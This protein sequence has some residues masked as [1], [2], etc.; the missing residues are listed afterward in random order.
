VDPRVQLAAP[1]QVGEPLLRR[2]L[3]AR[4]AEDDVAVQ[5]VLVVKERLDDVDPPLQCG[6]VAGQLA[7]GGGA[8]SDRA[9]CR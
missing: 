9:G 3:G 4:A 5:F 8:F 6:A 2:G 1:A 7:E